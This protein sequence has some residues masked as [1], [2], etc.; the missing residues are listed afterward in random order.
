MDTQ[1]ISTKKIGVAIAWGLSCILCFSIAWALASHV[2]GNQGLDT[3][4]D[5]HVS[6]VLVCSQLPDGGAE[7]Q[8]RSPCNAPLFVA[9]TS[10]GLAFL[11][12]A[13]I[14]GVQGETVLWSKHYDSG[15]AKELVAL[16]GKRPRHAWSFYENGDI[17]SESKFMA[18]TSRVTEETRQYYDTEGKPS[19]VETL[20]HHLTD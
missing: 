11:K 18:V 10:E 6:A 20:R 2:G 17:R 7:L 4:A 15:H 14:Y 1:T 16:Y 5:G 8:I 12:V 13:T 3:S 9:K 19:K